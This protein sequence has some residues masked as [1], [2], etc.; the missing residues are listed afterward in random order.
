MRGRSSGSPGVTVVYVL[1]FMLVVACGYWDGQRYEEVMAL[2]VY[3]V[4]GRLGRAW[5]AAERNPGS[6]LRN[7]TAVTTAAEPYRAAS[8]SVG[9]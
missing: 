5:P 4:E 7:G 3:D 2:A 1:G 6:T 8:T 9:L